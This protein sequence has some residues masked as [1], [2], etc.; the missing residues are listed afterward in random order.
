MYIKF[1]SLLYTYQNIYY[2][3]NILTNI[4]SLLASDLFYLAN[5]L[6]NIDNILKRDF[7]LANTL[8]NTNHEADNVTKKKLLILN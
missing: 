6:I 5:S 4:D 8:T 3:G 7:Y 1:E 2:L